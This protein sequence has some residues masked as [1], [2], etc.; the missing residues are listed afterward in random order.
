MSSALIPLEKALDFLLGAVKENSDEI[1]VA[2]PDALGC[3]LATSQ[4]AGFDVPDFDNSAMD[5]YAVNTRDTAE[6]GCR[7]PVSQI[8]AAGQSLTGMGLGN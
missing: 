1:D 6:S 8:I 2:L 5:G 3:V 4:Q 7:L